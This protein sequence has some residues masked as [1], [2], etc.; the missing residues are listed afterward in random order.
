MNSFSSTISSAPRSEPGLNPENLKQQ[1][2]TLIQQYAGS[3][4]TDH[5]T[6]DPGITILEVLSF[7]VTDL[8]YRL[9][10]PL[11]DLLQ[12]ADSSEDLRYF[13][14][15][16][17]VLPS[18][19]TTL[20]DWQSLA[21][22]LR[23]VK[24]AWLS[25]APGQPSEF[26]V[27]NIE[28]QTEFWWPIEQRRELAEA[29][30]RRLVAKRSVGDDIEQI[31]FRPQ[32]PIALQLSL[33]LK[34][35]AVVEDVVISVLQRLA[36]T[37][38]PA[39]EQASPESES[40]LGL[41]AEQIFDGPLLEN[42]IIL[43][44]S[45]LSKQ[46]PEKLYASD[47][48]AEVLKEEQVQQL[49]SLRFAR[50]PGATDDGAA[51]PWSEV[52]GDCQTLALDLAGTLQRLEVDIGGHKLNLNEACRLSILQ[53]LR[54][55]ALTV[56][57]EVASEHGDETTLSTAAET[58]LQ[59][60]YRRL[61]RYRSLQKE[62]PQVYGLA[63]V[64]IPKSETA[65]RRAQIRQLQ[66]FL[67]LFDQVLTNQFQQLEQIRQLLSLPSETL[68]CEVFGP[69]QC[70]FEL[71]FS[72]K[73]LSEFDL[74]CFWSAVRCLPQ[75]HQSQPLSDIKAVEQLL[76]EY[77]D[78]YHGEPFAQLSE[79]YFSREQLDRLSRSY[80][81][82]LAR[83]HQGMF[84][85]SILKYP[86][87]LSHYLQALSE[88]H[89]APEHLT[90]RQMLDNLVTLK[91]LADMADILANYPRFSRE[92][93]GAYNYLAS[94][95]YHGGQY[96]GPARSGLMK[97]LHYLLGMG[98]AGHR[99]LAVGNR[100]GFHLLEA[101]ILRH[102]MNT[103]GFP[104]TDFPIRDF[105][106][107]DFGENFE[108]D[109][110]GYTES[111]SEVL[112]IP[113]LIRNGIYFVLPAWPTRFANEEFKKLLSETIAAETPVHLQPVI[114][115]LDRRPMSIFDRVYNAWVNAMTQLPIQIVEQKSDG[116]EAITETTTDS[117]TGSTATS[118]TNTREHICRSQIDCLSNLLAHF[119]CHPGQIIDIC[120]KRLGL[121][122]IVQT[123]LQWQNEQQLELSEAQLDELRAAS[124]VVVIIELL[125]HWQQQDQIFEYTVY[126]L[127]LMHIDRLT[128]PFS[129]GQAQTLIG[130][131]FSIGYRKIEQLQ[132]VAPIIETHINPSA[133]G[134]KPFVIAVSE[135]NL[136]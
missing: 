93:A 110:E 86:D 14:H 63:D 35:G 58:A 43:D 28:L 94:R 98:E 70:T 92:R 47:L 127:C 107:G 22:D 115:C 9:A 126:N 4:W 53:T 124:N 3:S 5:N 11:K 106:N 123:I 8:S 73:T 40:T 68:M 64:E 23:G 6:H 62:F 20:H 59:G 18:A 87:V 109:F 88:H 128:K 84:D 85:T 54:E 76:G 65:Q 103:V 39:V 21:V 95:S 26:G 101:V 131:S 102:G 16:R 125:H 75:T 51:D 71:M 132:P 113:D 97:R 12:P 117:G 55:R 7:V 66:G 79:R 104:T 56:Q 57:S 10:F 122:T 49:R 25:D 17:E 72:S 134:Q 136:I 83:Y 52:V 32:R 96:Q 31:V 77:F 78:D 42:G 15:Q 116:S 74:Q 119:C 112:S 90:Q 129:I 108:S 38:S 41:S 105:S 1:A 67:L 30:R 100:E 89:A 114:I 13:W 118:S 69:I 34:P 50:E 133:R 82:L 91:Q 121:Q 19:P 44:K 120:L 99:N 130:S 36:D 37:I 27:K 81:H 48:I 61:K 135:P 111:D 46:A 45:S 60:R 2:L 33:V 80:Q 29:V 24:K